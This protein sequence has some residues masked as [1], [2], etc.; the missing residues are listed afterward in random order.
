LKNQSLIKRNKT[1][2]ERK[3]KRNKEKMEIVK[4]ESDK[5]KEIIS[6]QSIM[7]QGESRR[8]A[9]SFATLGRL[10][11]ARRNRA[12]I[13]SNIRKDAEE[14]SKNPEIY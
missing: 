8:R 12:E 2:G 3:T 7:V 4:V 13:E 6:K 9:T 11:I 5:S 10:L 14:D 1:S